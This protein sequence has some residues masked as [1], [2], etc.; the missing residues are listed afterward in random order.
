MSVGKTK[1]RGFTL[2]EM[3]V[4]LVIIGIIASIAFPMYKDYIKKA[5]RQAAETELLELAA[6]QERIYVNSNAYAYSVTAA[7][8]GTATGGLGRTTGTTKDGKYTLALSSVSATVTQTYTLTATPVAGSSQVG[9][10]TLSIDHT[11]KRLWGSA[12]W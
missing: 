1:Y 10:G 4:V 3:L 8:D 11:N 5:S 6:L 2:V 9:D 12:A 7:Y